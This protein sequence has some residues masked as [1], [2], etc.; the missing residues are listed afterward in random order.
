MLAFAAPSP[1]EISILSCVL[2]LLLCLAASVAFRRFRNLTKKQTE[3]TND[4]AGVFDCPDCGRRVSRL[5]VSCPQ[6][7][8]PL[9]PRTNGYATAGLCVGIGSAFLYPILILQVMAIVLSAIGLAKAGE[10]SGK[11]KV[12]AWIGLVLGIVYVLMWAF[13]T[14]R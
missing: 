3:T 4:A 6:C 12:Q 13:Y 9:G 1:V 11:G 7:G 8:R 2:F 5:A 10:R 14:S